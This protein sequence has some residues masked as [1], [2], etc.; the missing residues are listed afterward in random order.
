MDL[1]A[2]TLLHVDVTHEEEEEPHEGGAG[3]LGSGEEEIHDGL[4]DHAIWIKTE[5][6][7]ISNTR[8]ARDTISRS[9]FLTS[10]SWVNASRLLF[11]MQI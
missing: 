3:R 6:F 11:R 1:R 5:T 10:E 7:G 2:T 8:D 9:S 4:E